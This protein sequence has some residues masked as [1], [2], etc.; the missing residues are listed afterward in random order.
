ML[1]SEPLGA[2]PALPEGYAATKVQRFE[3]S[4]YLMESTDPPKSALGY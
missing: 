2:P 4:D 3:W 1:H